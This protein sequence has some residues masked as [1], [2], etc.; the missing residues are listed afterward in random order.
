M[1]PVVVGR[2]QAVRVRPDPEEG[3]VAEVEEPRVTDDDVQ[4][5][6]QQDVEQREDPVGEEVA[7]VHPER[8]RPREQ[9]EDG[10][11]C[12]PGHVRQPPAQQPREPLAL[13]EPLLVL[14]D[15]VVVA[16]ARLGHTFFSSGVPSSPCGRTSRTKMRMPNTTSSAQRPPK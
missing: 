10:Q 3:D 12:R 9:G 13:L 1:V 14:G 6:P 7:A 4:P 11:L 5:Q 16:Y 2:E 15:P 8:E